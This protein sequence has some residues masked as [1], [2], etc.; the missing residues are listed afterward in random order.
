MQGERIK[1]KLTECDI[2]DKLRA[3]LVE[4]GE[5]NPDFPD[6]LYDDECR[7]CL[8]CIQEAFAATPITV[9]IEGI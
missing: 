5:P 4:P 6:V 8:D 1:I 9:S 3:C 2:C 7:F